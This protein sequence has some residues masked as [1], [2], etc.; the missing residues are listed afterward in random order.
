MVQRVVFHGQIAEPKMDSV[1]AP[2][3]FVARFGGR[4]SARPVP[5]WTAVTAGLLLASAASGQE[6]IRMSVAGQQAADAQKRALENPKANLE[7]GPVSMRFRAGL[8][9]QATDNVYNSGI[10]RQSDIYFQPQ[11]DLTGSWR[12]TDRNTLSLTLGLGY[13]A[14]L[15]ATEYNGFY[16]APGSEL[17]FNVYAGDVV[18]N[19]HNRFSVLQ[20][21]A[22]QPGVTGIGGYNRLENVSGVSALWDLNDVLLSSGYDYDLFVPLESGYLDQQRGSHLMFASASFE[23]NGATR[24]GV[25][26]GG[27]LTS[28]T[29][30]AYNNNQHVSAGGFGSLQ[31]SEY[32]SLKLSAGYVYYHF[33]PGAALPEGDSLGGVYGDLTFSQRLSSLVSHSISVGRSFQP[34]LFS[35][36]TDYIYARHQASWNLIRNFSLTTS[37]TY[38]YVVESIP[39]A[40]IT[41]T[42]GFGVVLGRPLTVHL[43]GSLGYQ[44]YYRNSNV[45]G[46]TYPQNLVT[47]NLNYAF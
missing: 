45:A 42:Y 2:T 19:V 38:A 4:F 11:F 21:V 31:I 3:R 8:Q 12:A 46:G 26:L 22:D 47:L 18:V 23:I 7:L 41:H 24:L 15:N 28:Y 1:P 37:L 33:D 43:T 20:S 17:S 9:V 29:G 30:D 39:S 35:D 13:T 44:F 40:Q 16:V 10:N 14:Y 5:Y 6:A 25:Q 34:G 36:I 32:S 27:G